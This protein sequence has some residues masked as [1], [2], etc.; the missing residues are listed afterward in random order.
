MKRIILVLFSS[1]SVLCSNSQTTD[2][3]I[4]LFD[5]HPVP[6]N[7]RIETG[8]LLTEA[9][10]TALSIVRQQYRVERDGEFY[11]RKGKLYYGETYTLGVKISNSTILQRDAILPW[12]NDDD[13]KR[14]NAGR[15]YSAEHLPSFQR[16][17]SET[18][19][20]SV[21]FDFKNLTRVKTND[22]LLY[23]SLDKIPDFGLPI[24]ESIGEKNGY[25]IWVYS[26]TNLQD[27]AMQVTQKQESL[28]VEAKGDNRS[29][30]IKPS[31]ADRVLGGIF[32]IPKIERAGYIQVLLV[33]VAAKDSYNNWKLEMLTSQIDKDQSEKPDKTAKPRKKKKQDKSEE[34]ELTPIK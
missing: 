4:A 30:D 18:E 14:L 19:W 13:Y 10:K 24:D 27:S 7:K 3:I 16:Q 17:L 6:D 29:I 8:N 34:S 5:R 15:N 11:G 1:F 32:V 22:S 2:Q 23:E 20:K 31:D 9:V 28:S 26:T 25:M 12:E 33:G 21:E